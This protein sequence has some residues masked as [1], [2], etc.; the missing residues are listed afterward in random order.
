MLTLLM[1]GQCNIYVAGFPRHGFDRNDLYTLCC[2]FGRVLR[3]T[4]MLSRER[5]S[6][7]FGFALY[8]NAETAQFAIQKLNG[9]DL[10]NGFRAR[11]ELALS[12]PKYIRPLSSRILIRR[13]PVDVSPADVGSY[14]EKFGN[15]VIVAGIDNAIAGCYMVSLQFSEISFAEAAVSGANG[16]FPFSQC[17]RSLIVKMCL[18]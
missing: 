10:G 5:T 9:Y 8:E 1:S 12:G 15:V 3:A 17:K 11:A 7:G 16:T 4:V 6:L 13:V 2:T 14:F 18:R